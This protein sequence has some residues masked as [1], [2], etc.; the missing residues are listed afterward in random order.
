[1]KNINKKISFK[2][3]SKEIIISININIVNNNHFFIK[4][5]KIE[6][7]KK[8]VAKQPQAKVLTLI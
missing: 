2:N 4:Q 7:K 1:M 3:D 8:P 6:H 5:S